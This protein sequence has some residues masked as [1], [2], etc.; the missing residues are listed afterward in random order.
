MSSGLTGAFGRDLSPALSGAP[1]PRLS[2]ALSAEVNAAVL[3][4]VP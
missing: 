2:V 4:R 1:S 3:V